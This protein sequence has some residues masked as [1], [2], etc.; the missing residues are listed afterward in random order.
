MKLAFVGGTGH[1]YLR[2]LLA[3]LSKIED[4][5]ACSDGYTPYDACNFE[6][7]I[8]AHQNYDDFEQLLREFKPDVVN[9]G[10]VYGKNGDLVADALERGVKVVSDKPIAASAEQLDRIRK[11]IRPDSVLLTEFD[12]RCNPAFRAAQRAVESGQIGTVSMISAQKSYRF[13]TRPSWYA[14]RAM[15]G[16]TLLWIASHAIDVVQFVTGQSIRRATGAQG[17][18]SKPEL[19]TFEDHVA[20]LMNLEGGATAIAHADFLRPASAPTHG[21][22]RLRVVGSLGA[23][24]VRDGVCMLTTNQSPPTD[25]TASGACEPIHEALREA[26]SGRSSLFSTAHSLQTAQALLQLRDAADAGAWRSIG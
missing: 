21:D 20:L 11:A 7:R 6:Q 12:L 23:I 25:I 16:G 15:Y 10:A 14:D 4:V 9:I 8:G 18:L 24:E 26:L 1:H 3:D 19:G 17:N 22:D 2:G 13:G 5:A